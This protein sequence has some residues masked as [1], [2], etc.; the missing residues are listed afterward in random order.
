[1]AR[2]AGNGAN[3][4]H[5][6]NAIHAKHEFSGSGP[7]SGHTSCSGL[8]SIPSRAAEVNGDSS[9]DRGIQHGPAY[10][11]T[12][13]RPAVSYSKERRHRVLKRPVKY[14]HSDM[15]ARTAAHHAR[16]E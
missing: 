14:V 9:P 10:R 8:A 15:I 2:F 3:H 4:P 13:V 7:L 1:M 5:L 6:G 11:S 16:A 12:L